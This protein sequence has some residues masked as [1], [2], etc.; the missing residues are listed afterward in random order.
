MVIRQLKSSHYFVKTTVVKK[1]IFLNNFL[2]LVC[3]KIPT[4]RAST[5][6]IAKQIKH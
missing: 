5:L 3:E 1:K 6:A 4:W 2:K